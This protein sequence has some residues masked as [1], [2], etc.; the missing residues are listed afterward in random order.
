MGC[1][2]RQTRVLDLEQANGDR[3]MNEAA[4]RHIRLSPFACQTGGQR[5]G[6]AWREPSPRARRNSPWRNHQV[7]ANRR[8]AGPPE[9]GSSFR[10]TFL[11]R[12]R[13][14]VTVDW[15]WR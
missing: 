13:F 4:A 12:P 14:V 11:A 2:A 9:V 7:E 15:L 1:P 6:L 3:R 8:S 10:C 5:E